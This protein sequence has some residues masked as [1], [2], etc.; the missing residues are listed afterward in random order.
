VSIRPHRFRS[1]EEIVMTAPFRTLFAA[2]VLAA[3]AAPTPA[4]DKKPAAP[5]SGT[6]TGN[7][8]EAK[9]AFVTTK[10]S[11]FGKDNVTLIFTE[12]DASKEKNPETAAMFNKCGSALIITVT[13]EGKIVG[14]QV[15]HEA[16]KKSGFNDIGTLE[17][18]D[19]KI[20]DGKLTGQLTT[21]GVKDTFGEKWEVKLTFEAKKP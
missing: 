14:C 13:P 2:A 20:A 21:G 18:K 16:H 3:L 10:K 1:T 15:C 8:K 4:E 12:K 5:V 19:F 11:D 17:T 7:G 9:L 6:F